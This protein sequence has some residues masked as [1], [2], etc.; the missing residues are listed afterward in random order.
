MTTA[1]HSAEHKAELLY[2]DAERMTEAGRI[3]MQYGETTDTRCDRAAGAAGLLGLI[4]ASFLS[5]VAAA[6]YLAW[7]L[8]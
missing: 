7:G 3:A 5:G 2:Q 4:I 8:M 6:I 1:T